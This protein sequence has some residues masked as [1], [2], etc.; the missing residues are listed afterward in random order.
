MRK[1]F[2]NGEYRELADDATVE[3]V[4]RELG[5]DARGTAVAVN[6]EVIPRGAWHD[7]RLRDGQEIEVLHA[8]QG[9]SGEAFEI[10]GRSFTAGGVT[11]NEGESISLDGTTGEVVLG[12]TELAAAE[13]PPEFDIILGWADTVR[14]TGRRKLGVRANADTGEDAANARRRGRQGLLHRG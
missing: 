3:T 9:G 14:T 13:P 2:V 7:T 12:E 10:A 6:G 4:V 1:V 5:V 11:V 8:V